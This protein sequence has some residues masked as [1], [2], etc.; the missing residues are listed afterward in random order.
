VLLEQRRLGRRIGRAGQVKTM[1]RPSLNDRGRDGP[2]HAY[3][4]DPSSPQPAAHA[5]SARCPG[6]KAAPHTL[7]PEGLT[8]LQLA[9]NAEWAES[10]QRIARIDKDNLAGEIEELAGPEFLAEVRKAHDN[11]GRVLGI[12]KAAK[13]NEPSNLIDPLRAVGKAIVQYAL[14]LAG[15]AG[16]SEKSLQ[17]VRAALRPIDDHRAASSARRGAGT[18]QE[19]G[20]AAPE[21][22][23]PATPA[24]PVPEVPV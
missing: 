18:G 3:R 9:Y 24:T 19:E 2:A 7:F 22:A 1:A 16:D 8:F 6:S 23:P 5:T 13:G 10:Q 21:A 17:M 15:M 12:T 20:E 14:K 11:Y 4:R